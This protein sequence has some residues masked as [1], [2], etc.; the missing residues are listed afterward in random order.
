MAKSGEIIVKEHLEN[1]GLKIIKI[2]E[3]DFKTVDFGVYQ[4]NRLI[5]YLEEKTIQLTPLAWKNID[6]IYGTIARH[7]HD[8]IRQFKS[9]NPDRIV[10]NVLSL[11]SMDQARSI[12]DLEVTLTGHV[13]TAGGKMRPI[14]NMKKLENELSLIDLY[15]WFD[16]DQLAGHLYD[17]ANLTRLENLLEML[18]LEK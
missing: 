3:G 10:P 17:E 2:P 13:I 9:I 4:E 14:H 5:C 11:T 18:E 6:P 7:I 12:D 8:A 15:L 16:H 1:K